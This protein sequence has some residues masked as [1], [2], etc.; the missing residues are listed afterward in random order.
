MKYLKRFEHEISGVVYKN[1][2]Y[3]EVD[4]DALELHDIL[5]V[6]IWTGYYYRCFSIHE[7]NN[8]KIEWFN[9]AENE[10]IRKLS[11]IEISALKFN[12]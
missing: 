2:D 7:Y 9:I 8:D 3:V 11:K 4:S 10:I 6:D 12:I 5:I 1:G